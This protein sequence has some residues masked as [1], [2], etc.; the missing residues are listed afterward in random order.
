MRDLWNW[1]MIAVRRSPRDKRAR[2]AL[3]RVVLAVLLL[4]FLAAIPYFLANGMAPR[5]RAGRGAIITAY[6]AVMLLSVGFRIWLER[7]TN[8]P[9]LSISDFNTAPSVHDYLLQ[10]TRILTALIARGVGEMGIEA[11][12]FD[13]D[14]GGRARPVFNSL[15][16]EKGLWEK[17]EPAEGDLLSSSVGTWTPEQLLEVHAWFEQLRLLRWTLGIDSTLPALAQFPEPDYN[18]KFDSFQDGIRAPRNSWDIR[19]E[20]DIA[21]E[22]VGRVMAE[23]DN[24]RLIAPNPDMGWASELRKEVEGDSTDY[25]AGSKTVAE[26]DDEELQQF[27]ALVVARW[28]YSGYLT[29]LL[30]SG[31]PVSFADWACFEADEAS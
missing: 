16:R 28:R 2:L 21:A 13:A 23:L 26:L 12:T 19:V 7:S 10:R 30:S 3:R 24:R 8:Q 20:R 25:L 18:V 22:Y 1:F 11:G 17:L 31:E 14:V 6:Y 27:G 5:G 9:I 29:D 15:L 4:V